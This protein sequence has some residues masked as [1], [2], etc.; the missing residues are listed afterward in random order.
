MLQCSKCTLCP[1]QLHRMPPHRRPRV[2]VSLLMAE[3]RFTSLP[4]STHFCT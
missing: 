4:L 2:M 3:V 1:P